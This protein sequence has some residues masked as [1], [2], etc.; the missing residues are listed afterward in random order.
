VDFR[1]AD[2]RYFEIKQRHEAGT[3]T[4]EEFDELLKELMVEDEEGRWWAK[5]R[6]TGEWHYNDGTT[7]VKDTPPGYEPIADTSRDTVVG[8]KQPPQQKPSFFRRTFLL[9]SPNTTVGWV[10]HTVFYMILFVFISSLILDWFN[11]TYD[12]ET[13]TNEFWY[14]LIGLTVI[15]G[16]PLLIVQRLARR[17]AVRSEKSDS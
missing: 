13:G 1:E 15:L 9:Y 12:P 5:S 3:L 4:D 6:R 2:R 10:L 7:W 8:R 14:L 11:P 17:V 16:P